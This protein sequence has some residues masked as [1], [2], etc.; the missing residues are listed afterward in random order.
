MNS[1]SEKSSKYFSSKCHAMSGTGLFQLSCLRT[2][3]IGHGHLANFENHIQLK[4][5]S[6]VLSRKTLKSNLAVE[7]LF[8]AKAA[9]DF[10]SFF[11]FG[12]I[13]DNSSI[14]SLAASCRFDLQRLLQPPSP[15][16]SSLPSASIKRTSPQLKLRQTSG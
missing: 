14:E 2:G 4:V 12:S 10:E 13:G 15:S 8:A 11:Q 9:L 7:E 6:P 1:W 5:L 3:R 16:V